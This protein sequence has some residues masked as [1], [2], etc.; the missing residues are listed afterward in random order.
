MLRSRSPSSEQL[1]ELEQSDLFLLQAMDTKTDAKIQESILEVIKEQGVT[2]IIKDYCIESPTILP[3]ASC[4]IKQ[5]TS[6]RT[7]SFRQKPNDDEN[8]HP[9]IEKTQGRED[10]QSTSIFSIINCQA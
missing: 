6:S 3:P 5:E 2:T 7:C 4:D 1:L 10:I 9:N 8:M